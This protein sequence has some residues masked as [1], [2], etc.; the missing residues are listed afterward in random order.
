MS[1]K[2]F[3]R[4][5]PVSVV[6][7]ILTILY[8]VAICISIKLGGYYSQRGDQHMARFMYWGGFWNTIVAI[9]CFTAREMMRRQ[10]RAHLAAGAFA[11]LL[12]LL[13]A[14]RT[15]VSALLPGREA[16]PFIE[17]VLMWLAMLYSI[18]YAIL[19]GKR[20]EAT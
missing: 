6:L 4:W 2:H 12:A 11:M 20:E 7:I 17:G 16:Y 3:F 19:E 18:I 13:I 10:T 15:T 14:I 9:L 5:R 1:I 8:I